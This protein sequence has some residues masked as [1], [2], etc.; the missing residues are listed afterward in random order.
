MVRCLQRCFLFLAVTVSFIIKAGGIPATAFYYAANPPVN[1]LA[2]YERVILE[3]DNIKAAQLHYLQQQGVTV[4]AY[5]SIGE[6]G[7]DRSWY[8]Q[9]KEEWKQ[10]I[11]AGWQSAVMDMTASGWHDYLLNVRIQQ[12]WQQGYR[13][14]FLD[15]MD[16]YQ[17]FAKTAIDRR[18][19]QEGMVKLLSAMKRQYKDVH[20][21]F[22][23]GFE[24]LDQAADLA[25]GL[26]AESLYAGWNA[27]K[28]TYQAVV[29]EDREWL[30]SKLQQARDEYG[31]PVT[32]IDYLPVEQRD[33]AEKIAAQIIRAGFIPWVSTPE[34]NYMGVGS[35]KLIPRKVLYLFDSREQQLSEHEIHRFLAM[36]LEYLGYVPEYWDI[37]EG[38][39]DFILQGRYAG[40]V[41]WFAKKDF[42]RDASLASWVYQQ[43]QQHLPIAF[44]G[45]YTLENN[46]QLTQLLDI[47]FSGASITSPVALQVS[48]KDVGFETAV[49]KRK[50]ELPTIISKTGQ[51]WLTITGSGKGEQVDPVFISSWGG[52]ALD[53]YILQTVPAVGDDVEYS[54]WIINPFAFLQTALQLKVIPVADATTEN[55]S[56]ILTLHIDGDG[57]YNKTQLGV[58][59][60]SS[61]LILDDFIKPLALPH[62][63]SIIEGEIGKAGLKPELSPELETIAREIF[64]LHHVEIASHTYSHPF[65][66]F[67]AAAEK[68][69]NHKFVDTSLQSIFKAEAGHYHL[70]IPG[71]TYDAEREIKGSVDYIDKILAPKGK[72]TKVLLWSGDCLPNAEA[73][74]WSY[75]IKLANMNGGDTIIRNGINSLTNVSASGIVR[76]R[77][78]Q[79]YAPIQNENVYTNDWT[80]PYYGYQ[81]VIE[82]FR[83]TDSPKRLKPISIYYHF[84]SGDR[85]ASVRALRRV[86]DW[87]LQQEILPLWVSEYTPRLMAFRNAVYEQLDNGWRIHA[88]ADLR[89]LRLTA[90][91]TQ[92]DIVNSD[93][94][95]GFRR[96]PQGQFIS[97]SG[98]A[99]VTLRLTE[100]AHD[101]PYLI[102]SNARI[103]FWR[104]SNEAINFRL[105]GHQPVTFS[106]ANLGNHCVVKNKQGNKITGSRQTNGVTFFKFIN[107]DTDALRVVCG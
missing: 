69:Q 55:G 47:D 95:A 42:A 100:Q 9:I 67:Q 66:W 13:G 82:T 64:K 48:S 27:E 75:K 86:Y 90:Q 101:F 3:P 78:F 102:Q 28:N 88:A 26:V 93:G 50:V 36:P 61:Q 24:I 68:E 70:P 11:N 19:Q 52:V 98:E 16:S 107:N 45:K 32:V 21:L 49:V 12:L 37:N 76:E 35:R 63:V 53:P 56:R 40:I 60:Y 89:T 62:T 20:L 58:N 30:L 97:L 81:R 85:I 92:P 106:L 44:M 77:Y 8:K 96:L 74:A 7:P 15:T 73:L 29:A 46:R 41:A 33:Q 80:G 2:A 84:Y 83:L 59:R 54:R 71:Y 43:V 39:P 4:Y 65:N 99:T 91:L 25:D 38:L 17:L 6:V 5:L 31:L 105:K 87:A 34:L 72:T 104:N 22:N 14:F 79:P 23:R 103:E 57:F 51:P 1:L 94:V 10:G 18:R